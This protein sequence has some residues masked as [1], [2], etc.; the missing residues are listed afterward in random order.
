MGGRRKWGWEGER[1]E[2]GV[3]RP[4]LGE[5]GKADGGTARC[6]WGKGC[7]TAQGLPT[8][9][10]R[11]EWY[12]GR[13]APGT[14]WVRA[15]CERSEPTEWGPAQLGWGMRGVEVGKL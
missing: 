12:G 13:A 5:R 1:Q 15:K 7:R 6:D 4:R 9:A 3:E 8:A 10:G 14:Q 11:E 2:G